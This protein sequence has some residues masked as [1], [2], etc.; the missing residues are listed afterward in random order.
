MCHRQFSRIYIIFIF[1]RGTD[2]AQ[3][4]D[5]DSPQPIPDEVIKDLRWWFYFLSK[6]NGISMKDFEEWCE[7]DVLDSCLVGCGA[8][9]Q[10]KYFHTNF[11]NF[12]S[13]QNRNIKSLELL[14]VVV[15]LKLWS[16]LLKGKKVGINCDN[17][18]SVRV[19]NRGSCRG[20]IFCNN[21]CVKYVFMT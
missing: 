14:T 20:Y 12:I 18:T 1:Q 7:P 5:T 19:L 10:G 21:V 4:Q 16:P 13:N 15:A 8:Y 11:P 2:F 3:I 17:Q 6:F 9:F